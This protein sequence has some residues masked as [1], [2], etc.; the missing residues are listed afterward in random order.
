MAVSP[1]GG[2][3]RLQDSRTN[4]VQEHSPPDEWLREVPASAFGLWDGLMAMAM[5]PERWTK[6]PEG[7]EVRR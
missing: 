3:G 7:F 4:R 5:D 2:T 6:L 1:W